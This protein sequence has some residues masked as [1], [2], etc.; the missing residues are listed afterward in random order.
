[1]AAPVGADVGAVAAAVPDV[2]AARLVV[3]EPVL[4]EA[5]VCELNVVFRETGVPVPIEAPALME[6]IVKFIDEDV[7]VE[8]P[9]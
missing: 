7:R 3:R 2:V 4:V 6:V 5:R 8:V 1:M 9:E